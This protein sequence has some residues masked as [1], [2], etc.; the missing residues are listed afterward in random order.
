VDS[1][2]RPDWLA[3]LTTPTLDGPAIGRVRASFTLLDRPD[4]EPQCWRQ[5]APSCVLPLAALKL[6][7][8]QV[9]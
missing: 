4:W 2:A 6:T 9:P 8:W 1:G 5:A 7:T 3:T